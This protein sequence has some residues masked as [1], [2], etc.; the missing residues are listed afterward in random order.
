LFHKGERVAVHVRGG[1]RG[2]HTKPAEHLPVAQRPHAEWPLERIGREAA[3]IG[4]SV[5]ALTAVFLESEPHPEQA[6]RACLGILRLLRT[7]G[8]ERLEAPYARGLEIGARSSGSIA[9]IL[10]HHLDRAPA[11]RPAEDLP[12][13]PH[14]NIRGSGYCH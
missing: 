6:F 8:R 10:Q 9:S 1:L 2:R 13:V 5:R 12:L 14:Q 3:A 7:S 11:P 4:S